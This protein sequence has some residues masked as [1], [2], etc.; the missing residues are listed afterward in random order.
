MVRVTVE[1]FDELLGVVTRPSSG[2]E[3]EW[4]Q[5]DAGVSFELFLFFAFGHE[6]RATTGG[7]HQ[8]DVKGEGGDNGC[9][10]VIR[11]TA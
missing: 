7:G 6:T 10:D 1:L 5:I 3:D 4:D 11:E 2:F 9:I 8:A